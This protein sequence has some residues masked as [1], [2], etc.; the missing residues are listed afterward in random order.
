[1]LDDIEVQKAFV[2]TLLTRAPSD[3]FVDTF[4]FA[5][6][7]EVYRR[8][9][10]QGYCNALKKTYAMTAVYFGD[11]EFAACAVRYVCAYRPLAGQLFA[12]Y[13]EYFSDML[14]DPVAT[15]LARLEW[16]LQLV[17]MSKK[18]IAPYDEKPISAEERWQLRSDVQLF[19]SPYRIS[20]VYFV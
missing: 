18:D 5:A 9:F 2:R 11:E 15:E 1:M 4:D 3:V 16:V 10:M 19:K 6:R 12:T 8:N 17:L 20:E 13:G 14:K 7:L